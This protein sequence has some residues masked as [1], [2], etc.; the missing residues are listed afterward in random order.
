V[1]VAPPPSD[2][3]QLLVEMA[4]RVAPIR[5]AEPVAEEPDD[6]A[7]SSELLFDIISGGATP[8]DGTDADEAEAADAA[9]RVRGSPGGEPR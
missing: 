1:Y 7:G 6:D 3:E 2:P 8:L 9:S 5:V 4:L